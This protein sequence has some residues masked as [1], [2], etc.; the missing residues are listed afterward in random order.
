M[1]LAG[2]LLREGI[3]A[4]LTHETQPLQTEGSNLAPGATPAV[5]N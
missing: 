1:A 3:G 2:Y 5:P 4:T